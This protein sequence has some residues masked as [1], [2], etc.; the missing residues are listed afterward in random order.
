ME[1]DGEITKICGESMS[2]VKIGP[3][4]ST[5]HKGVSKF[6]TELSISLDRFGMKFQL[7]DLHVVPFSS[8]D[9]IENG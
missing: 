2:F 9:F 1:F 5:L 8:Y 6:L 4:T 3:V 7:V